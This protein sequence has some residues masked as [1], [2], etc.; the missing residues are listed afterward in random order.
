MNE[1]CASESACAADEDLR[2]GLGR[3][4]WNVILVGL[5]SQAA[6]PTLG[7]EPIRGSLMNVSLVA[8]F[9]KEFHKRRA[10]FVNWK[11]YRAQ[12]QTVETE[13]SDRLINS[14]SKEGATFC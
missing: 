9:H 10:T 5:D 12:G 1:E 2:R 7:E 6:A 11:R 4:F 13:E 14:I 3:I 8:E